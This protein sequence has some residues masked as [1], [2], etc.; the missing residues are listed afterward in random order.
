MNKI[1]DPS[2]LQLQQYKDSSKLSARALLHKQFSTNPTNWMQWVMNQIE[3]P[4]EGRVLEVGCGP[5]YLWSSNISQILQKWKIFLTDFSFGMTME[6]KESL[7]N[8][9]DTIL[10]LTLDAQQIPLVNDCFD[11]VIANHMLYHVPNIE[12]GLKEIRRVLKASGR[13]YAATNGLGHMHEI[14]KWR[15]LYFPE[16]VE[17]EWSNPAERF[18]LENGEHILKNWFS[19]VKL[20]SY[21]DYLWVTKVE[22][23]MDYF[24]SYLN[25]KLD[26]GSESR[27]RDFLQSNIDSSGGVKITKEV[28]LFVCDV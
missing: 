19:D 14:K 7:K 25:N 24:K 1:S 4:L 20:V 15:Q 22:P 18:G 13:L 6:A 21:Q 8:G 27:F 3:M 10:Y 9:S 11:T 12:Q 2:Y 17:N 26:S 5:G 23:I 28:G 16:E